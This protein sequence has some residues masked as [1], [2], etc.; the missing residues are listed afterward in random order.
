MAPALKYLLTLAA[1]L[2]V[3]FS[4]PTSSPLKIRSTDSVDAIPG[5]YIVVFKE[6]S[7]LTAIAQH[8]VEAR[9]LKKRDGEPVEISE[10]NS[11]LSNPQPLRLISIILPAF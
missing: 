3:A 9:S 7:N 4:A 11:S 1:S 8:F 10:L 2:S 6:N 5:R